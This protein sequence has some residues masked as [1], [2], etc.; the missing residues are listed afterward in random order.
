MKSHVD[1]FGKHVY[2]GISASLSCDFYSIYIYT[3]INYIYLLLLP[4]IFF[5]FLLSLPSCWSCSCFCNSHVSTYIYSHPTTLTILDGRKTRRG[6]N[7]SITWQSILQRMRLGDITQRI[8]STGR[9]IQQA[10]MLVDLQPF[11]NGLRD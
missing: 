10:L 6:Y 11:F 8:D 1:S 9:G 7:H 2:V 5:H 4:L 3:N